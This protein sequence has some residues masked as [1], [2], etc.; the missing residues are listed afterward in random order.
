MNS[1]KYIKWLIGMFPKHH[2]RA[3]EH[4]DILKNAAIFEPNEDAAQRRNVTIQEDTIA[5]GNLQLPF[6]DMLFTLGP[7][8]SH[9]IDSVIMVS[10]MSDTTSLRYMIIGHHDD[11]NEG[12]ILGIHPGTKMRSIR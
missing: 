9:D 3:D 8:G 4:L 12:A 7:T 5:E 11:P 1:R 10:A 2:M 6:S